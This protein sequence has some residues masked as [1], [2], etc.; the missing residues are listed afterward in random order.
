[1]LWDHGAAY[2]LNHLI[3]RSPLHLAEASYV[4]N[5]GEIATQATLPNGDM[6]VALLVPA[7]LAASEGLSSTP[8]THM[9]TAGQQAVPRSVPDPRDR[10]TSFQQRPGRR[11]E[12]RMVVHDHHRRPHQ[13]IVARAGPFGI[14]ATPRS[15]APGNSI[16]SGPRGR[17]SD[18]GQRRRGRVVR[19]A[20]AAPC[21]RAIRARSGSI[22]EVAANSA[23]AFAIR[24]ICPPGMPTLCGHR[25]R[26]AAGPAIFHQRRPSASAVITVG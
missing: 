5:R 18:M 24:V 15:H 4:N 12:A 23:A 11:P 21:R 22:A 9:A 25:S 1:V 7:S 14:R 10:F 13:P 6:H 3:G 20:L 16:A 8:Y 26:R 2:H 17:S 19:A